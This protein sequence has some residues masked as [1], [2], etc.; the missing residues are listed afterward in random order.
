MPLFRKASTGTTDTSNLV[1][2]ETGKSLVADLEI[3]K[4]HSLRADDQNLSAFI[5]DNDPRLIDART[6]TTHSHPNDHAAGSDNQDLS[7]FVIKET[8][9]GLSTNDYTTE[10]KN[11]LAGLSGVGGGLSQ[12]QIRRRIC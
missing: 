7:S 3:A 2:K 1:V 12:A 9:K 4:I 6:P 10:E 8:G 5:T 11:K